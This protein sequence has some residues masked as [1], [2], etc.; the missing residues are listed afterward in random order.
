MS[1]F[2]DTDNKPGLRRVEVWVGQVDLVYSIYLLLYSIFSS[3]QIGCPIRR[4]LQKE[5]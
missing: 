3:I 5:S 2:L 4:T 1:P